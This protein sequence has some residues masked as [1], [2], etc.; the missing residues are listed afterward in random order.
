MKKSLNKREGDKKTTLIKRSESAFLFNN[1]EIP[2]IF[3]KTESAIN[4]L[5][6]I[7]TV[8][9][10][11]YTFKIVIFSDIWQQKHFGSRINPAESLVKPAAPLDKFKNESTQ[12]PTIVKAYQLKQRYPDDFYKV[13]HIFTDI[14]PSVEEINIS[15]TK[16]T[17]GIYEFYFSLKEKT[18]QKWISQWE[19]SAGMFRTFVYLLEIFLA[20]PGSVM[21]IDEI[22]NGL[23]TNCMPGLTDF[24]LSKTS[25]LQLILT[26]HH[27]DI[28]NNIPDDTWKLVKRKGGYVSVIN[29]TDILHQQTESSFDKFIQLTQLPE[30]KNGIS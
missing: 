13:K 11:F 17:S 25:H 1:E 26:S 3:K 5:S 2:G 20:P 29:V 18:S 4:I 10:I 30:Y 23:G 16:T 8:K 24:I 14:F 19:M 22:E 15:I 28:I 7:E 27:P 12:L 9:K 6:K 21:V